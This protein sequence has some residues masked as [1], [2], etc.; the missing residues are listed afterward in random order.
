MVTPRIFR[1]GLCQMLV[2]PGQPESNR[3][4]A[5]ALV[6]Q[7][8][9]SGANIAL[10]P[11]CC[12]LGWTHPSAATLAEP[13]PDGATFQML[14]DVAR[15]H[16]IYVCAGLVEQDNG[17]VYNTAALID[18]NG[19]LLLRHRKINE[20]EIGHPF[21]A[22]GG[23]VNVVETEWG[24]IGVMICADAFAR[25]LTITRTLGYLGA[26]VILS[27]C[28]WAVP[29]DHDNA[30]EP[31]GQL[32]KDCYGAPAR[33]F[34]LWIAGVSN[35]GPITAGPW[36]GWNCIGCS[37][38]VDQQGQPHVML[39]YGKTAET[40]EVVQIAPVPRPAWGCGW[41]AVWR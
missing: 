29:P 30:R 40:V 8:A 37:L 28:A 38:V 22:L 6:E 41:D 32:W 2:T 11:E 21:Y 23:G 19:H 20:L 14:A 16:H 7:A 27:P 34:Q 35:V 17:R 1:L 9:Q 13:V 12:N 18:R 26:D 33:A 31:Y 39:P 5:Q 4:R 24:T 36:E 3:K 15:R 25:D 10:L